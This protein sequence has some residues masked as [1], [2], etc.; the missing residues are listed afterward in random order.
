MP[1][2]RLN[3]SRPGTRTPGCPMYNGFVSVEVR[4]VWC[5]PDCTQLHGIQKT[6]GGIP[7]VFCSLE[8]CLADLNCRP[9]PYQGCALPTAPR[10]LI[11]CVSQPTFRTI[12]QPLK[13]V[14]PFFS[15]FFRFSDPKIILAGSGAVR[16]VLWSYRTVCRLHNGICYRRFPFS[17]L[18]LVLIRCRALSID[19]SGFP[20]RPAISR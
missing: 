20:M 14:N 5:A 10:Q 11:D 17:A 9:H 12:L 7:G 3:G 19:F 16:P 6:P 15:D 18:I 13:N 2:G 4:A 1:L 8:S